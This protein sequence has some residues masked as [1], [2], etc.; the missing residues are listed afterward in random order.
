MPQ[1]PST[2]RYTSVA[3]ALHWLVAL[4]I[5][6]N[7]WK[8]LGFEDLEVAHP[9]QIRAAVNLH[10]SIGI[11]LIGLIAMRV[12][13]KIG[14]PAPAPLPGLKVWERKL[15]VSAHHVLYLLMVLVP[16]AGWL[17]DS[18]WKGAAEHPLVLFGQVPWFRLPL[19]GGLSDAGKDWWH[20][21]FGGVH[22]WTA[23]LLIGV[24]AL[25][26]AGAVKHQFFDGK[27]QFR[28]IWFGK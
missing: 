21:L 24:V 19:F 11:T 2:D 8:G 16:L 5:I 6:Y 18:A 28:R 4:G 1:R 23:K 27:P 22:E 3:V 10:K 9:D 15:S 14:H 17:H 12:L 13:W 25:H 20:G 26:I 7:L